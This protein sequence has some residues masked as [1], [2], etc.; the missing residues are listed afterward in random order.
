MAAVKRQSTAEED[1]FEIW[2]YIA[3]DSIPEA[4]ELIRESMRSFSSWVIIQRWVHDETNSENT[5]D[6]FRSK[7]M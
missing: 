1:L 2:S 6:R 7:T 5:T 3:E 4:N